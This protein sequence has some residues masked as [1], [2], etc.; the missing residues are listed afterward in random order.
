[1][2]PEEISGQGL[3]FDLHETNACTCPLLL[4]GQGHLNTLGIMETKR[5]SRHQYYLNIAAEVATRATCDR[6]HVG[7]VLVDGQNR[8]ISTGY[9][10]SPKGQPHCDDVGHQLVEIDGRDSCVRTLH[11]ESNAIDRAPWEGMQGATLYVTVTPCYD[12]AK[13]IVSAGITAVYYSE[14]YTSRN[15]NLV[16]Q[17]F[18]SADVLLTHLEL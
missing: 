8:I 15:T 12:C 5:L 18:E 7:A 3:L 11:A 10:G 6:K 14:H 2:V 9:N 13:R 17:L 16:A 4:T 1:M